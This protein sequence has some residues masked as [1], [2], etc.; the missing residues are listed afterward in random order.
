M[1]EAERDLTLEVWSRESF[2][3]RIKFVDRVLRWV[4]GKRKSILT[5]KF[6]FLKNR[7]DIGRRE[8]FL[9]RLSI[10]KKYEKAAKSMRSAVKWVGSAPCMPHS[11]G[12]NINILELISLYL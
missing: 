4:K 10:M 11:I 6:G 5:P 7:D 3:W 2:R 1:L 9:K 8:Y 12:R